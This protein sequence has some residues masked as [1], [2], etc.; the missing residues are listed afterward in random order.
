V[1]S[2]ATTARVHLRSRKAFFSGTTG[3]DEH[4]PISSIESSLVWLGGNIEQPNNSTLYSGKQHAPAS[5]SGCRSTFFPQKNTSR[6]KVFS[7]GRLRRHVLL[8]PS[9]LQVHEHP[10]ELDGSKAKPPSLFKLVLTPLGSLQGCPRRSGHGRE[11]AANPPGER[12]RCHGFLLLLPHAHPGPRGGI[13][14]LA[15]GRGR[16]DFPA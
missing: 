4:A 10:F 9:C 3:S 1:C 6:R 15:R 12:R 2:C 16:S 7:R 8:L 13:R 5:R 14:K 11:E